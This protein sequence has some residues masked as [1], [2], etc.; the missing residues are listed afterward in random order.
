MLGIVIP[1]YNRSDCLREALNSLTCQTNKKFFVVVVDDCST[2]DIQSVV[3]EFDNKL[4][5]VYLRQEINQGPGAA[6]QRGLD[7]VSKHNMDL[8]MFMDSDDLLFPNAVDRLTREIN[9]GMRD[10][11]S[12]GIYQEE[13]LKS[14]FN[15]PADNRTWLHGKIYRTKYLTNNNINF[16]NIRTNEDLAFN[17]KA[18]LFT[19]KAA[20]IEENLYLFRDDSRSITRN[21]EEKNYKRIFSSDYILAIYDTVKFFQE[22]NMPLPEQIKVDT[23]GLY[24]AYQIGLY[25]YGDLDENIKAVMKYLVQMS[26]MQEIFN[27]PKLLK[28]YIG[29]PKQMAEY[30]GEIFWFKQTF[31]EWLEE[32]SK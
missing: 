29:I 18:I 28:H 9:R 4:H 30:K 26:E 27:N 20:Y 22:K 19:Q 6:R 8:I 24:N 32:M 2:E 5:T 14:G 10:V 11:V 21:K 15:L 12:S 31:K 17:L 16:P 1:A 23:V 13:R 25:L 7:W 3:N